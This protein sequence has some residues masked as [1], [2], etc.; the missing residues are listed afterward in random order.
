MRYLHGPPAGRS[1]HFGNHLF[2]LLM[3]IKV[4]GNSFSLNQVIISVPSSVILSLG[5]AHCGTLRDY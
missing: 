1:P 5:A 4:F 3:I 2:R